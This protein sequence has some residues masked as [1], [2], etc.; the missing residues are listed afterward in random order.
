MK[1]IAGLAAIVLSCTAMAQPRDNPVPSR[2]VFYTVRFSPRADVKK[3]LMR[4]AQ[5]RGLKAA[6]IVTCVGSLE[7]VALRFANQEI[8]TTRTGHFEIV[9]LTGTLSSE[10]CH[11]HLAVSD[12][13]GTTT[14]G[15][16]M[17]G[18]LVYTTAE[19]TLVEQTEV[20]F[21][22]EVDDTYGYRE[23]VVKPRKRKN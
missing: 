20:V 6:S 4:F 21:E 3:E 15:H 23:L 12:S 19:V 14:G 8:T 5:A 2:G 22:R 9:S 13:V 7:Q 10:A 16:V 11:L 18:N 17:D 1:W